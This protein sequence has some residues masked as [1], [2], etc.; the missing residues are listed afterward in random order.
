MVRER[1]CEEHAGEEEGGEEGYEA[2]AM[3]RVTRGMVPTLTRIHTCP[4]HSQRQYVSSVCDEAF[5]TACVV[6][7]LHEG[8][9]G[10]DMSWQRNVV[11]QTK[12]SKAR[13][14]SRIVKSL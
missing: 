2:F 5:C 9:G 4:H 12:L 6:L 13:H 3:R 8:Q 11:A 14:L 10:P 7:R 1:T